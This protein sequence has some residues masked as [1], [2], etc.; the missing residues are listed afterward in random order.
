MRTSKPVLTDRLLRNMKP[1][2]PGAPEYGRYIWD[3]AQQHFG[4]KSKARPAFYAGMRH[5]RT[6]KWTEKHL[7]D[8]PDIS[9][10]RGREKAREVI[11][12]WLDG[13]P[14]PTPG[15][16]T[17]ADVLALYV[18]TCLLAK[19]SSSEIEQKL[20]GEVVPVFG[21]WRLIDIR[22]EDIVSLLDEIA[23]RAARN[24]TGSKIKTGGPHAAQKVYAYLRPLFAWA[25]HKRI[26]RLTVNPMAGVSIKLVL[27][28]K[29]FNR[30][31]DH[32][33]SDADLRTIW[34]AAK[35]VRYPFGPLVRLLLMSG[36]R[37]NEIACL[38]RREIAATEIIIPADRRKAGETLTIPITRQ[39]REL[40]DELPDFGADTFLFSTTHGRKPVSGFS[41]FKMRFDHAVVE[42]G[43]VAGWQLHDLRR[44]CRTG[45]SRV[46]TETLI[47]ELVIGHKRSGIEPVYDRFTFEN[48]KR[49]ALEAWQDLLAGIVDPP[50]PN[51]V[52]LRAG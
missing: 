15:G 50:P 34:M 28:G 27:Q 8:Y 45:L 19:R 11:A 42:V 7:G 44:V 39:I 26:G 1:R 32:L 2:K 17:F 43:A 35:A 21:S 37:L 3:G 47:A 23:G 38:H 29:V 49:A 40:L 13:R 33:I 9:V 6:K 41:K 18:E 16:E 20:T 25:V 4:V 10:A 14:L 12:A 22:H 5:P 48:R 30:T 31:H 52:S 51:V 36:A 24:R 46:G